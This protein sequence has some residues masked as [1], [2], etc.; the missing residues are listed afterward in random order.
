MPRFEA[1]TCR[2][3]L[4]VGGNTDGS[5]NLFIIRKILVY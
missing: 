4:L 2:L 5:H 3:K 1:V